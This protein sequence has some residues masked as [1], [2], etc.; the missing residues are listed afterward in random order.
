[1]LASDCELPFLSPAAPVPQPDFVLK[2]TSRAERPPATPWYEA[3]STVIDRTADGELIMRFEDGTD[4]LIDRAGRTLS[5]LAAPPE[6]TRD[7]LAAYALG[8]V[9][10]LALHL[11]GAVLLH[12]SAVVMKGKAVVFSGASGS[13]KSTTAAMLHRL[14]YTVLSDDITEIDGTSALPAIPTIRLWPEALEALY[15]SAAAF[16]DRAPSW[17]KKLV[18]VPT[19]AGAHPI[20]AILV[21]EKRG[22]EPQLRR[23]DPREGWKRL[24][25]EVPTV[26]LPGA[27]QKIFDA[28]STLADRVPVYAFV[29]PPFEASSTIGVFLEREL[30]EWLR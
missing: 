14:G 26:R 18:T 4:F 30:A 29:A 12:A 11:Q 19:A 8:P 21:L 24:M 17:D 16:P 1:V 6:Y 7:D 27:E 23:L 15:G 20:A 5:L 22:G 13:G 9:L 28:T 3:V 2:L 10:T 25:A